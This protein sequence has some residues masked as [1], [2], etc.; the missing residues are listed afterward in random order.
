MSL[1][2]PIKTSPGRGGLGPCLTLAYDSGMGNGPFGMGWNM[3]TGSISRK[4][5]KSIPVY[6]DS[7][8]FVLSHAEDLV[9]VTRWTAEGQS[10]PV[11]RIYQGF[12]IR[13][14]KPRVESKPLVIER[15]TSLADQN[16][17]HWRTITG[18][19]AITVYG[20]T[21]DARVFDQSRGRKRIFS[22]LA[23]LSYDGWGNCMVYSYKAEDKVGLGKASS[24]DREQDHEAKLPRRG[25]NLYLKSIKYGNRTPNRDMSTWTPRT[26][27]CDW[28]FEVI[29]DYGEHNKQAP[30][31]LE[32][33]PWLSRKD[34]FLSCRSGFELRTHRLCQRILMFHHMAEELHQ[35]DSLV[36]SFD[37]S[38]DPSEHYAL[39]S[40]FTIRGYKSDGKS[41]YHTESLN[42]YRFFY[43]KEPD[44]K[45]FVPA[46]LDASQVMAISVTDARATHWVDLDGEGTPG[47]LTDFG[48]GTMIYE[49]NEN[50]IRDQE[51]D[52]CFGPPHVIKSLPS[53]TLGGAYA[54]SDLDGTGKLDLINTSNEIAMQGYYERDNDSWTEFVPFE[55]LLNADFADQHY[56]WLDVTGNGRLDRLQ[57]DQDSQSVTWHASLAKQGYGPQQRTKQEQP[58]QLSEIPNLY[59][60]DQCY[61]FHTTDMCGDGLA[62]IVH[63]YN[64]KVVYWPNIG[65][66]N[67]GQAV[68][69]SNA[70]RLDNNDQF[71]PKRI[72]M[73]DADGSGTA[74]LIYLTQDGGLDLY[75]NL[76]GNA[77]SDAISI[78]AFPDY[79]QLAS[80]F[81]M[82]ILGNGNDCLCWT[83]PNAQGNNEILQYIDFTKGRKPYLLSSYD[84]GCG[85][86]IV[87]TY[88]PSTKFYL[89][90][91]RQGQP[92]LTKLPFPVQ[93]V[94]RVIVRDEVSCVTKSSTYSYH[95]GYF[96]GL[97]REFRG[98][99]FVEQWDTI[100]LGIK[101]GQTCERT[102]KHTK[103][104]FLTGG[105]DAEAALGYAFQDKY[106][107]SC[108]YP[109]HTHPD[110]HQEAVRALK[111]LPLR[112]ESYSC[113]PTEEEKVPYSAT[114]SSYE[115]VEVQT[116]TSTLHG[117]YRIIPR[118]TLTLYYE[119]KRECP[120]IRHELILK[121]N[122][123]G[124]VEKSAVVHYARGSE[125]GHALDTDAQASQ[126]QTSIRYIDTVYTNAVR[127]DEGFRSPLLSEVHTYSIE[128]Y[129]TDVLLDPNTL[130]A[131]N[132]EELPLVLQNK[133]S[134]SALQRRL[135]SMSQTF[136]L[137]EKLRRLT[138]GKLEL[139]SVIDQS[140]DMAF[141]S[142][143]LSLIMSDNAQEIHH[144]LPSEAMTHG[145]YVQFESSGHWWIPS[146]R[147]LFTD[148][149][150]AE[151]QLEAARS[152]FYSPTV[153]ED[154]F[155]RKSMVVLDD[156][157][158]LPKVSIDALGNTTQ[159][160]Y[161]Y[162]RL[163]AKEVMDANLSRQQSIFDCFGTVVASA[164]MGKEHENLGDSLE[165]FIWSASEE[166]VDS[167]LTDPCGERSKTLIGNAG[168]RTF[169]ANARWTMSDSG[170]NTLVRPAF[171]AEISRS[172]HYRDGNIDISVGVDY[173][174]GYNRP[175]QR[176]SL[177]DSD[178]GTLTWR[179]SNCESCDDEGNVLQRLQPFFAPDPNFRSIES[180]TV[181]SSQ[182][183]YDS[184]NRVVAALYPDNTWTKTCFNAWG[185]AEYDEGD[186]VL[187]DPYGDKD[188]GYH[189]SRLQNPTFFTPWQA[190]RSKLGKWDLDALAKS[191]AYNDTPTLTHLDPLGRSIF[192][193][194]G[195]GASKV[196]T[197][198]TYDIEG[199]LQAQF[200]EYLNRAVK[201]NQY[202][203]R[204]VERKQY[205][206]HNRCFWYA[207]MDDGI[208]VSIS[209]CV[210]QTFLTWQNNG[211]CFFTSY[212]E[213]QREKEVY[214][215]SGQESGT[216]LVRKVYGDYGD[217]GNIAEAKRCN[218]LARLTHVYDQAGVQNFQRYDF[219]GNCTAKSIQSSAEY[220]SIIDWRSSN[221]LLD[222]RNELTSFDAAN[223]PYYYQ[224]SGGSRTKRTY[225]R[226]GQVV[227]VE[228]AS[229]AEAWK[230]YLVRA[231]YTPDSKPAKLIYGN[232]SSTLFEYDT[233][234][235]TLVSQK[236]IHK[237]G[238]V[239][240][241][242]MHTYD[243]LKQKTHTIDNANVPEY[244][245]NERVTADS[246]YTYD[247][248]GRLIQAQGREQ[249]NMKS[250][251]GLMLRS[252]QSS[253]GSKPTSIGD[254]T[255]VCAYEETYEY[256]NPGNILRMRH[257]PTSSIGVSGWTRDYFYE[258]PSLLEPNAICNRLSY[259]QIG[260]CK[261][262][263][264]YD[265]H[266][267]RNGCITSMPGFSALT[268]DMHNRLHSSVT[269]KTKSMTPET[270]WYVYNNKGERVRKVTERAA[271]AGSSP[272]KLKE[273]LFFGA[274]EE[275]VEYAGD[276][277]TISSQTATSYVIS[278][279]TKIASMESIQSSSLKHNNLIR[280]K[281]GGNFELDDKGQ[282]ISYEEYSPFGST[283]YS[284]CSK[285]VEAPREY[286]YASYYRDFET[287]LFLC[288]ARY[289]APWLGRWMSPDPVG[290]KEGLNM[291][292]Y[293][294]SDPI[295]YT[296]VSGTTRY[297]DLDTLADNGDLG[298]RGLDDP[299]LIQGEIP[300][301]GAFDAP[302]GAVDAYPQPGFWSG[303]LENVRDTASFSVWATGEGLSHLTS[304]VSNN[305]TATMEDFVSGPLK[306]L[307][308][309]LYSAGYN[310]GKAFVGAG[311][312][313][314][315]G[316]A[317]A[318]T[319]YGLLSMNDVGSSVLT[320][321]FGIPKP[322][323]STTQVLYET[324]KGIIRGAVAGVQGVAAR[325]ES[326]G[327][328]VVEEFADR[329]VLTP[330]E[331]QGL[332]HSQL[333]DLHREDSRLY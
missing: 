199:N 193:L 215:R 140:Y 8:T 64:G 135:T 81:G 315:A 157:Q 210:D 141:D 148:N 328:L 59:K 78:S 38:Y 214:L 248:L 56:C 159:S 235:Q 74:D 65:Y 18:D 332:G 308:E 46:T 133:S 152:C 58:K 203:K 51:D 61:A 259:T 120:R 279:N 291:Y 36:S 232:G 280:Y 39:L 73:L 242:L 194:R 34:S 257:M 276:G 63:I 131:L 295:N 307:E 322:S 102:Q 163:Q 28:L 94:K 266:A 87:I 130:N 72:R 169:R 40:S 226:I 208:K 299:E 50:A 233:T 100:T 168:V 155:K 17:D 151:K 255:Q 109:A 313:Y 166:L 271:V 121:V 249:I 229:S 221:P 142:E 80:V 101:A 114:E 54:F 79:N 5:S 314:I 162:E 47:L 112:F 285:G 284:A 218:T 309:I 256:D 231:E 134:A 93:C 104:W 13:T 9:P 75:Y 250:S 245:R 126:S 294:G 287:G 234:A 161:D 122:E 305:L 329:V 137:G 236:T 108:T 164:K 176:V 204:V 15:W 129:R 216:L 97:E 106:H 92:W 160:T 289:Y 132:L 24:G 253:V 96:D 53:L 192:T 333:F 167:F 14:F 268:W 111:G 190:A 283:T 30:S 312:A 12:N 33:Q 318:L 43:S 117:I 273:T 320:G 251:E 146:E 224:D 138:K 225:N 95:D 220:K 300:Y 99:G 52:A 21:D 143:R 26:P 158:L 107:L 195:N 115:V 241:D 41:G 286:R 209:N 188:I 110:T 84:N 275:Y 311:A 298:R 7:D 150:N 267:G 20:Q 228:L 173:L 29:L 42:P 237:D 71:S 86:E 321:C 85:L 127:Q 213:L 172:T 91:E 116:P 270:T 263:Y 258:E 35:D 254:G 223:R 202:Q 77:W 22:W 6:D 2:L 264:G 262:T 1:D 16:D 171:T 48:E 156:Y 296:D 76:S 145:G 191:R 244:F 177:V 179:F 44:H 149:D 124:D 60:Q 103:S 62:D 181:P 238:A 186:T 198:Y 217:A 222:S 69:M 219:K 207:S 211:N 319:A 327:S 293:V 4:A 105:L 27:V 175:F 32:E 317:G 324:S 277:N 83:G 57:I 323:L 136:Y 25:P 272:T 187:M 200:D 153:T 23:C 98:F 281:V 206:L 118:E 31:T 239:Y 67:F 10:Q 88:Q 325:A 310:A 301:I 68:V 282:L 55:S 147:Y 230:P 183:F 66:G 290:T 278:N 82:D 265:L 119:C 139:Y 3:V 212:D 90:H 227:K 252:Y 170:Q 240:E 197:L 113:Q 182:F 330:E 180:V 174:D 37:L 304:R 306:P 331:L 189:M 201:P 196:K 326:I 49:R 302:Q 292:E 260:K 70:P 243:C 269:Q 261:E 274:Y 123:Y 45:D 247:A 303:L 246:D 316:P 89:E 154:C 128:N 11:D 184:L 165:G 297:P 288:G 185:R 144:F 178:S 205:D 125:E 19:N